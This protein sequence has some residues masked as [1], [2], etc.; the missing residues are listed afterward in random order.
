MK[1]NMDAIGLRVQGDGGDTVSR[2]QPRCQQQKAT[3]TT[4]AEP[5]PPPRSTTPTTWTSRTAA[6]PP[7]ATQA[8]ALI[9]PIIRLHQGIMTCWIIRPFL[10]CTLNPQT[11]TH[12][13][14]YT[15]PPNPHPPFTV[16]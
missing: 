4:V 13:S 7:P 1:S 8:S 11:P 2:Y 10:H 6:A 16:Y 9:S 12:P 5:P 15:K 14:L 3:A